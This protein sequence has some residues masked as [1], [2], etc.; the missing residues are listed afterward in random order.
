MQGVFCAI[1]TADARA[2]ADMVTRLSGLGMHFKLGLEFFTA[3]G[4][5][6]VLDLRAQTGDAKIFLDLKLHDIPHT[7][8]GAVRAAMKCR[9]DFLT[10]HASG[11][12]E[13]LR[14]AVRAAAEES[15]R[16]GQPAPVLL[17]VTVLTHLD[18]VDLQAVGQTPPI[19]DQVLR[20]AQLAAE[21]GLGGIVCSPQEVARLRP[22]LPEGFLLVVP[23][24][25]P[26]LSPAGDQKRTLA[27]AGAAGQGADYLVIGRPITGA[28]DPAAAARAILDT[29]A[30]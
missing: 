3:L 23:G 8:A 2:A 4:P 7:V 15:A 11:G 12:R 1:D 21:A 30:A 28:D 16:T 9:A 24:I 20:L 29:L 10:L 22:H 18:E 6:G 17:G 26:A 19:R 27:P 14:A 5:Q 25:R 13:M